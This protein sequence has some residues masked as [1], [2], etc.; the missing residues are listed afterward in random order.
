MLHVNNTQMSQDF[1][2]NLKHVIL[3]QNLAFFAEPQKKN[4]F[5]DKSKNC[6]RRMGHLSNFHRI[7]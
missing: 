5:L 6:P 3:K 4:V 7:T 2:D 1:I